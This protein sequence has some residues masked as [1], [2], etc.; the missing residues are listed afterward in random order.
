[1]KIVTTFVQGLYAFKYD[2]ELDE[3]ERLLDNWNSPEYLETFFEQNE[4]DLS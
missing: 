3:L 1:M 4:S 2:G